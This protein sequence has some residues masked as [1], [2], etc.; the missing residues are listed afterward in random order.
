MGLEEMGKM[1][2]VGGEMEVIGNDQSR[3]RQGWVT[4]TW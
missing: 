2:E 1:N 3:N 4:Y